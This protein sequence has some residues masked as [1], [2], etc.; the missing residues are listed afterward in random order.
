[1]KL[2]Q[3]KSR[4][5]IYLELCLKLLIQCLVVGAVQG[6]LQIN[7][8]YGFAIDIHMK[9]QIIM[10]IKKKKKLVVLSCILLIKFRLHYTRVNAF[11]HRFK[12][13]KCIFTEQIKSRQHDAEETV[14]TEVVNTLLGIAK[15]N[16][17]SMTDDLIEIIKERTR[18][19][20]VWTCFCRG[21]KSYLHLY[22]PVKCMTYGHGRILLVIVSY[23]P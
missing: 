22:L 11:I 18:D 16:F 4:F 9:Y 23:L 5:R 21:I 14:R 7:K 6:C 12:L 19:K 2:P 20:K 13:Y 10:I 15:K 17:D 1:M 3:E 8:K